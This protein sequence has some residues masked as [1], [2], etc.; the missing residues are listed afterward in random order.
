MMVDRSHLEHTLM[1]HLEIADLNDIAQR[2][3]DEQA[4]ENN[5][6][7]FRMRGDGHGSEQAA[8]RQRTGIS[9]EN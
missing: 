5:R 4:A 1:R 2:F 6:E 9:H 3:H 8:K 7:E